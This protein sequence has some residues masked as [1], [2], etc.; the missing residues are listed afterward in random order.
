MIWKMESS[1][2]ICLFYI[3]LDVILV[4]VVS[5]NKRIEWQGHRT[6]CYHSRDKIQADNNVS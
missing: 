3:G 5:E 4:F 1:I 2:Y 6:P